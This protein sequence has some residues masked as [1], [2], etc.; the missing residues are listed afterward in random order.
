MELVDGGEIDLAPVRKLEMSLLAKFGGK[1]KEKD[2]GSAS[3][4]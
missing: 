4:T 3:E 2:M 1:C